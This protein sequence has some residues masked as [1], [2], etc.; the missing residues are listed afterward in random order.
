MRAQTMFW[1]WL[2]TRPPMSDTLN[3]VGTCEAPA[4]CGLSEVLDAI[5][6][7]VERHDALRTHFFEEDGLPVQEVV[8]SGELRIAVHTIRPGEA[9]TVVDRIKRAFEAQPFDMTGQLPVRA[10]VV[11]DQDGTPLTVVLA[12]SHMA[13]DGWSFQ[14]VSDDLTALLEPGRTLPPRAQQPLERAA[15]EATAGALRREERALR[16]WTRSLRELPRTWLEDLPPGAGEPLCADMTSPALAAALSLL[17]SR[18]RMSSAMILQAATALLLGLYRDE[19]EVGVQLQVAPRFRPET[20]ELV[21]A[22]NLPGM[23]RVRLRDEPFS[24]FLAHAAAASMKAYANCECDPQKV[25]ALYVRAKTERGITTTGRCMVNALASGFE[26]DVSADP[27]HSLDSIEKALSQTRVTDRS[28]D[29]ALGAKFYLYILDVSDEVLLRLSA[30]RKF[31]PPRQF[32]L[33]LEWL[34][35]EGLKSDAGPADLATALAARRQR[36]GSASCDPVPLQ[37]PSNRLDLA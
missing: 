12:A 31:L 30:D 11:T 8:R 24:I 26:T 10:A 34:V 18:T 17:R 5:R 6:A 22:F 9:D 16:H 37:A 36:S 3:L 25:A 28:L 27:P 19:N 2:Q 20:R 29:L 32:L 4:N 23:F 21:G 14:I 35:L 1:N 13:V 15:Y 7:L 33:D